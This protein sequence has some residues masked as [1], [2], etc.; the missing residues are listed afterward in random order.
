MFSAMHMTQ[1]ISAKTNKKKNL[2]KTNT[3]SVSLLEV[4]LDKVES[5]IGNINNE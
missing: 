1:N 5:N 4:V 2:A 3:P